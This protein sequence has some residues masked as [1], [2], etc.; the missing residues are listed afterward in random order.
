MRDEAFEKVADEVDIDFEKISEME[1]EVSSMVRAVLANG[2]I[3][4]EPPVYKMASVRPRGFYR[5]LV[6][7]MSYELWI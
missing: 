3:V 5:E 6:V 2:K 1:K 7:L 4:G